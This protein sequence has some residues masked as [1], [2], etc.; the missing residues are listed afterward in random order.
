M[1][2]FRAGDSHG[3]AG[4][5][6]VASA[7]FWEGFDVPGE[8]LQLVV[9]DKLPFPP[10]DDPLVK[11]RSHRIEQAGRRAFK[12]YALPE[13][14][15]ALRQGAGRL[16]RHESD[17][18]VLVIGDTRLVTKGYGRQLLA[19]LP[20]MRRLQSEPEFLEALDALTRASTTDRSCP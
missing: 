4:C 5:I 15:V 12:D 20:S 14:A 8:A 3:Q 19:A 18:G 7:S 10:P 13:A 2:R 17:A 16:I 1:E 6:L 9:I 11:A